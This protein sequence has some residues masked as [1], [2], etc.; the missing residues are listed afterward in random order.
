M[1]FLKWALLF[2]HTDYCWPW[3]HNWTVTRVSVPMWDP[4]AKG[5]LWR[6]GKCP[7]VRAL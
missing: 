4:W 2:G 1:R 5:E 3:Q 7:K 6:C